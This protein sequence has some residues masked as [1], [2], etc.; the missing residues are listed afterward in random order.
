M[1]CLIDKIVEEVRP[2]AND[3]NKKKFFLQFR[4]FFFV[5]VCADRVT[6]RYVIIY[7]CSMISI[8]IGISSSL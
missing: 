5:L 3:D 4:E 2:T 1:E 7:S 8:Y 6:H